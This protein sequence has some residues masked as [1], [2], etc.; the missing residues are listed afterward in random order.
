[1]AWTLRRR[2]PASLTSPDQAICSSSF[3]FHAV[4]HTTQP[5]SPSFNNNKTELT[6]SLYT[7]TFATQQLPPTNFIIEMDSQGAKS[8]VSDDMQ[9]LGHGAED[10]SNQASGYKAA[11]S[12]PSEFHLFKRHIITM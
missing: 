10:I 6:L 8:V 9:N 12:N 11:I 2:F 1:L 7:V 4:C 3:F 5:S